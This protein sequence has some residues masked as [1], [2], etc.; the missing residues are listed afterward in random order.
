MKDT[1]RNTETFSKPKESIG[2][3][4]GRNQSSLNILLAMLERN[5]QAVEDIIE[6]NNFPIASDFESLD[7]EHSDPKSPFGLTSK[8]AEV[9]IE[10][11]LFEIRIFS[12]DTKERW[13]PL[14]ESFV[15][16]RKRFAGVRAYYDVHS[17]PNL[18][19]VKE[20]VDGFFI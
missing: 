19:N 15:E 9:L 2:I 8:I 7:F 13:N 6:V 4:Q 1:Y 3:K 14:N 12:P 16:F 17:F 20:W 11:G 10:K 5:F 18:L